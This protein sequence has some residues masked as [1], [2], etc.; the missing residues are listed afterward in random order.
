MIPQATFF[1]VKTDL[2]SRGLLCFHK[3]LKIFCSRHRSN[4]NVHQQMNRQA[5]VHIQNRILLSHKKRR[6]ECHL[7]NMDG[8][9]DDHTK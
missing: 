9:R 5:A 3:N 4:L 2:A 1:F 8:C 6:K 7:H